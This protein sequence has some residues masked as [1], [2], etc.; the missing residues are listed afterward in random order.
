MISVCRQ[1]TGLNYASNDF[2][3]WITETLSLESRQNSSTQEMRVPF[4]KCLTINLSDLCTLVVNC[5]E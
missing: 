5:F 1:T 3:F 2:W 4:Q